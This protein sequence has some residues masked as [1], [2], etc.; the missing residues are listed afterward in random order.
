MASRGAM[1][2][3][4]VRMM[5][6]E[7]ESLQEHEWQEAESYLECVA[8]RMKPTGVPV[9]TSVILDEPPA[10]AI[11]HAA[12]HGIDLIALETHGYSGLKRLWLGSVADK[13]IRGTSVP[14]LVQRPR[15]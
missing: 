9:H 5:V 14:I 13:V 12:E 4:R 1:V 2:T 10:Q 11:L 8:G 6:E 3:Q 7:L 15:H